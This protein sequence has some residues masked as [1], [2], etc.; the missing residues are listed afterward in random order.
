MVKKLSIC[1]KVM[2]IVLLTSGLTLVLASAA[3]LAYDRMAL[4][5]TLV[6]DLMI[7]AEVIGTSSVSALLFGDELTAHE[8]LSTLRAEP[9]I[10]RACLYDAQ[11]QAFVRYDRNDP[12]AQFVPPPPQADGVGFGDARLWLFHTIRRAGQKV[13]TIYI[14]LDLRQATHHLHRL[15]LAMILIFVTALGVAAVLSS[16]MQQLIC[17]PLLDLVA[18]ARRV[19]SERD[20]SVRV[21]SR[22]ED[23]IGALVAAFNEMLAEIERHQRALAETQAQLEERVLERTRELEK[24]IAERKRAESTV[25]ESEHQYRTLFN[26]IADPV[27]IVDQKTHQILDCNDTAQKV[28]GYSR[29][30]MRVMTPFDLH[31]Q[32]E[33]ERVALCIDR[34]SE[35]EEVYTHLTKAGDRIRVSLHSEEIEYRGRPAWLTLVRDVTEQV[36][37]AEELRAAKE[38]AEAANHAKTEFLATMSHEIRTPLNGIIGMMELLLD[39]ELTA[40]QRELARVAFESA[41]GLLVIINDILDFAK[42]EAGKLTIAAAPFDLSEAIRDVVKLFAPKAREKGLDLWVYYSPDAPRWVIGDAARIRQVVMNLLGNALKFTD[43]GSVSIH[44]TTEATSFEAESDRALSSGG[45]APNVARIRITVSDTGMG[46]PAEKLGLIF[47]KFSQADETTTRRYGGTGLGLA[48]CRQ[49]VE[50]MGGQIGVNSRVGEGSIF[51]VVLPLPIAEAPPA[52]RLQASD[53]GSGASSASDIV[54]LGRRPLRVL[55]VEDN[56][57]NQRVAVQMLKKLGHHVEVVGEG[58][59]AVERVKRASYDL[60]LMDC[61]MPE[62][63]GY[64]ATR[65]IRQWEAQ[66]GNRRHL[67]IIALTAHAL[68]GDRERCLAAGMDGYLAKPIRLDA[69]HRVI[70]D[71]CRYLEPEIPRR[72]PSWPPEEP[73]IDSHQVLEH[74][75]GDRDLLNE[76][77]ALF[78]AEAPTITNTLEQALAQENCRALERAAHRLRGALGHLGAGRAS[79]VAL[80]LEQAARK[81]DLGAAAPLV[82]EL[83]LL[84]SDVVQELCRLKEELVG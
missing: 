62:M 38:A 65:L 23:E 14:E 60:V 35:G 22:S 28:Y 18:A 26:S 81:G 57:I 67:P 16:A 7:K 76:I 5:Q 4:R 74:V 45:T 72:N 54:T 52:A 49:L 55:L 68:T 71:T 19:S 29:E 31:P 34:R 73:V 20:Y 43:E 42:I 77:I 47:E 64:E 10:L 53:V 8:V 17:G 41:T 9:R 33:W 63:D 11:G 44:V 25:R 13:G 78:L 80:R 82:A 24:E 58:R 46:I 66:Q 59:E 70:A 50:L 2:G 79:D 48:I 84:L 40:Q 56:V 61:Q 6:R 21:K 27:L 32:E 30:E 37:A 69:L 36:R 12:V 3:F 83:K 15:A 51:W 75:E 39:T 1:H